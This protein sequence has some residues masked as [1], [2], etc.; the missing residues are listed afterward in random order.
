MVLWLALQVRRGLKYT[1][2][3]ML[4]RVPAPVL[5]GLLEVLR[6]VDWCYYQHLQAGPPHDFFLLLA[7]A[8]AAA[9]ASLA[10]L[11]PSTSVAALQD[12][13]NAEGGT[14]TLK[15]FKFL[16]DKL[17]QQK[18][19]VEGLLAA[20]DVD[21]MRINAVALKQSLVPWPANKLA[22]LHKALPVLAAGEQ[23]RGSSAL[24]PAP[25]QHPASPV[26]TSLNKAP[27][28]TTVYLP[29]AWR[30]LKSH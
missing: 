26:L 5:G 23:C 3:N 13:D 15:T 16:L 12:A 18:A 22:E 25:I 21:I 29:V 30:L 11:G 28:T 1:G 8:P 7:G 6:L 19:D 17:L 2:L 20:A 4:S 10:C 24:K 27:S 14:A 9:E